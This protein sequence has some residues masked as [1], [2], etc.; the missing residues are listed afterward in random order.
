M[1]SS[2]K[3][4]YRSEFAQ[5]LEPWFGKSDMDFSIYESSKNISSLSAKSKENLNL[6]HSS[7]P[8]K[9]QHSALKAKALEGEGPF[10][11]HCRSFD[12]QIKVKLYSSI[13]ILN[14]NEIHVVCLGTWLS[15]RMRKRPFK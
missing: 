11:N 2:I 10:S 14:T 7:L 13:L 9:R 8:S 3:T 4:N 12:S 5:C 1:T 6:S 15:T